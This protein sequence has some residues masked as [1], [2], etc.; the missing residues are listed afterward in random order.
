MFQRFVSAA[1]LAAL[2][3]VPAAAETWQ[4]SAHDP[5]G[6]FHTENIRQFAADVAEKSG[7]GSTSPLPV[8]TFAAG[9]TPIPSTWPFSRH[10]SSA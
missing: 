2:T 4:M 10:S 3:A 8:F 9:R 6:N 5:D 7:G 1:A